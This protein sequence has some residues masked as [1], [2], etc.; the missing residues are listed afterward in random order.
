MLYLLYSREQWSVY[1]VATC[2]KNYTSGI[3]SIVGERERV[4]AQK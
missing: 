2:I 1:V 4:S 3:L